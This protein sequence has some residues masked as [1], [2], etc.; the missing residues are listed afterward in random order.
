MTA[1]ALDD[2][3]DLDFNSDTG[4]FNMIDGDNATAQKLYLSLSTNAGELDW[5]KNI[6]IDHFSLIIN[7][8]DESYITA[9]INQYL[10]EQWPDT[11]E[12]CEIT[13]F[14][15][16]NLHRLTSFEATVRLN[17]G[18]IVN[19]QTNLAEEQGDDQ[20]AGN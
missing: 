6:G 19:V 13:S 8:N 5:N 20:D 12:N 7:G 14:N 11:F 15:V 2:T 9:A 10:E 3:G 18:T 1:F 16:D 17:D 4:V